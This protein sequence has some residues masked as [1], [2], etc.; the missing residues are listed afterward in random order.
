MYEVPMWDRT[1]YLQRTETYRKAG[2]LERDIASCSVKHLYFIL[3]R[4]WENTERFF[5]IKKK[6]MDFP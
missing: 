4:G 1:H 6:Q 5:Y 2:K 3:R